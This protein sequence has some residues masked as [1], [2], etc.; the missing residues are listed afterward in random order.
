MRQHGGS[1]RQHDL[2]QGW[3]G[4]PGC[5]FFKEI[6]HLWCQIPESNSTSIEIS[7]IVQI[8]T[9]MHDYGVLADL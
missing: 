6:P 5:Q 1:V 2:A 7:V 9:F 3:C 8:P 4:I